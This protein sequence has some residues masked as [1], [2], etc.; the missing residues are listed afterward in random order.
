[1]LFWKF[2][3]V[4]K[5]F[6]SLTRFL[7]DSNIIAI[8]QIA[9][10]LQSY[11]INSAK[12]GVYRSYI[13]VFWEKT[14][15]WAAYYTCILEKSAVFWKNWK[16]LLFDLISLFFFHFFDLCLIF[17]IFKLIFYFEFPFTQSLIKNYICIYVWKGTQPHHIS[18]LHQSS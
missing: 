3:M 16:E 8:W 9:I 12:E 11:Q 13:Y 2:W 1:M 5:K 18:I 15:L 6:W 10:I 7:S 17:I 14:K 4:P